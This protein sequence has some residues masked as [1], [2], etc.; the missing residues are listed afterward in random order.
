MTDRARHAASRSRWAAVGAALAVTVGGGGAL[1]SSA[2]DSGTPSSFVPITPCRLLD[3]RA[4]SDNVGSRATP[5]GAGETFPTQVTGSNGA[6]AIPAGATAV[7]MNV[8][9]IGP[10]ASS[11]LTVFPSDASRPV[12]A[13]LNWVGGQAPTPNAVT[14]DLSADGKVSLYNLA[15]TV[16]VVVDV[17]GYY[18]A[19]TGSDPAQVVTVATSGGDF[20]SVSAALASITDAS[21]AKPY[22]IRIAPGTYTES[23]TLTLKA[24]V[25]I[26]GAGSG[27]TTITCAC[28]DPTTT[29]STMRVVGPGVVTQVRALTITNTG[30]GTD[31]NAFAA[32]GTAAHEVHL[33][34]VVLDASGATGMSVG[35]FTSTS[36]VVMADATALAHGT[37][38]NIGIFASGGTTELESVEA[39]ARGGSSNYGLFADDAAN[40]DGTDVSAMADGIPTSNVT[41]GMFGGGGS[42]LY[43]GNTSATATGGHAVR[44]LFAE[45]STVNIDGGMAMAMSGSTSNTAI[46]IAGGSAELWHVDITA[47]DTSATGVAVLGTAAVD[48][49]DLRIE[50]NATGTGYGVNVG[51]TG[52]LDLRTSRVITTSASIHNT[53]SVMG[54]VLVAGS[55]IPT[56]VTGSQP[57]V[58]ITS[59]SEGFEPLDGACTVII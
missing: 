35:L 49:T 13:N 11:F 51:G 36:R 34:H 21:A 44:G 59:Y 14:A 46:A 27:L 17:V 32:H 40:V 47:D 7:S 8:T 4:G 42:Q 58:C 56:A 19:E 45:D 15:G 54:S 55:E 1:I 52:S 31:A 29:S 10:S 43:F 23:A 33:Q 37:A 2:A 24:H 9:I 6:C 53:S 20:T 25:D 30:G 48:A 3:T 57:V 5:L 41:V 39:S 18:Q 50:T 26:E 12:S 28:A 22:V 38:A 16:D